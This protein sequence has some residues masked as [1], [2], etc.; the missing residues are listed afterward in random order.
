MRIRA[1][2]QGGAL[3]ILY[4]HAPDVS[5][6]TDIGKEYW[7]QIKQILYQTRKRNIVIWDSDNNGQIGRNSANGDEIIGKWTIATEINTGNGKIR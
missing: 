4:S 3:A 5:Y 6:E 7:R 2:I 1:K